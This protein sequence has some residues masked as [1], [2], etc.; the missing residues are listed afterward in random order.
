MSGKSCMV[1][2][3]MV[4]IGVPRNPKTGLTI[5]K[6]YELVTVRPSTTNPFL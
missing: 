1:S 4:I 5:N 6:S 3:L 2:T